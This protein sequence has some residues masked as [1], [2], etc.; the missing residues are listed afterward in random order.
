MTLYVPL[1]FALETELFSKNLN[2]RRFQ[3]SQGHFDLLAELMKFNENAFRDFEEAVGDNE[4][5]QKFM[6]LASERFIFWTGENSI[7]TYRDEM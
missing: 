3:V 2:A 7:G 6:N 4:R 1:E 5:F